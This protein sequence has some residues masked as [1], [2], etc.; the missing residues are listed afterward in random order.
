MGVKITVVA[1]LVKRIKANI[2]YLQELRQKEQVKEQVKD[3]VV[4]ETRNLLR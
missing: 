2:R 1:S 3:V 4:A